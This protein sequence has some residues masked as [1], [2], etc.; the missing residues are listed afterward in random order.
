MSDG[1]VGAT[2]APVAT[3]FALEAQVLINAYRALVVLEYVLDGDLRAVGAGTWLPAAY[4]KPRA[5]TRVGDPLARPEIEPRPPADHIPD[6]TSGA[7]S[8]RRS[9]YH[10]GSRARV[11]GY[12]VAGENRVQQSYC[13]ICPIALE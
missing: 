7:I 6:S 3:L 2:A 9:P 12:L 1:R 11:D 4:N 13:S 5:E 10:L 8:Q